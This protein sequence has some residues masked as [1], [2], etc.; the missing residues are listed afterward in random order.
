[1]AL[2]PARCRA[3]LKDFNFRSLFIEEMGWDRYASNLD[4]AT[5][6]QKF[7][8][9][10]IAEKRGLIAFKCPPQ[11]N[12]S[13]PNYATRRKIEAQVA[14]AVFEHIIIYTDAAKTTQVW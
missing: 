5:E 8:L 10:G 1:M 9:S 14:K 7:T 3:Y 6:E 4:V 12:D 2:I 13:I 11:A